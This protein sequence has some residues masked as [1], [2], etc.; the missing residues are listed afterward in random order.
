VL[1][2]EL[3]NLSL[4]LKYIHTS[5]ESKL[6]IDKIEIVLIIKLV[7]YSKERV[8]VECSPS[9]CTDGLMELIIDVASEDDDLE[10]L[11]KIDVD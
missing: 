5:W 6:K 3:F 4:A 9:L 8:S 10:E 11:A 7:S 1:V 2:D